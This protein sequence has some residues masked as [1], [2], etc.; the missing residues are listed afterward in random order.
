[1]FRPDSQY[2]IHIVE[3][4]EYSEKVSVISQLE[5]KFV[6]VIQEFGF[7]H[8]IY[9]PCF[10]GLGAAETTLFSTNLS[11]KK[12]NMYCD[13]HQ[14]GGNP[15]LKH[16]TQRVSLFNWSDA[17]FTER[18]NNHEHAFLSELE[19]VGLGNGITVPLHYT[20]VT[21]SALTFFSAKSEISKANI[22]M[23]S[24]L[25]P[26]FLDSLI[27]IS[28]L[29]FEEND[30]HSE[31]V[32][33]KLSAREQECLK[34]VAQGKTDADIAAIV[35]IAEGTVHA[36]VE[37]AKKRMK[38]HTRIQAVLKAYFSNQIHL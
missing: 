31:P 25:A 33:V 20:G 21:V 19:A 11:L 2:L 23:A 12:I 4:I 37:S 18:L 27:R 32:R 28:A 15:L 8:Y 29:A 5:S 36:H 16:A 17:I 24:L 9:S 35:N 22:L 6:E 34:W 13:T 38:V 7:E 3:F 14:F 1:L 26:V 10:G 30:H